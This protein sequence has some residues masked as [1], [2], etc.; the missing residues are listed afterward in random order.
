MVVGPVFVFSFEEEL[1][2]LALTSSIRCILVCS[3]RVSLSEKILLHM[4]QLNMRLE[5]D[6]TGVICVEAE[7]GGTGWVG[8]GTT[9][10]LM[11]ELPPEV[12][13][14]VGGGVTL[15]PSLM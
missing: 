6:C 7:R 3:L 5:E 9:T 12:E 4:V 11:V 8:R 14:V 15:D 13:E 10:G 2:N 1:L